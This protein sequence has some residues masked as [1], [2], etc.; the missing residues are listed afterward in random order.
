MTIT[1][2]TT[3]C[4]IC[5]DIDLLL[6]HLSART[7]IVVR[8]LVEI[9]VNWN[10]KFYLFF[11]CKMYRREKV[12]LIFELL[13]IYCFILFISLAFE[14]NEDKIKAFWFFYGLILFF[15]EDRKNWPHKMFQILQFLKFHKRYLFKYSNFLSNRFWHWLFLD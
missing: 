3:C 11:D 6:F 10:K 12:A 2:T 15:E 14:K 13:V 5:V 9:T 8:V 4:F 7:L 1:T